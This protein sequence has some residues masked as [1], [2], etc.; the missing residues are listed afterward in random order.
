MKFDLSN[1]ETSFYCDEGGRSTN[2]FL[3]LTDVVGGD[4]DVAD[5]RLL[6]AHTGRSQSHCTYVVQSQAVQ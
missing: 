5:C 6:D 2:N 4:Q 3:P 1:L